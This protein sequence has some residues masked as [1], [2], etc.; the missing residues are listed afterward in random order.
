MGF[1]LERGFVGHQF[2]EHILENPAALKVLDLIFGI[3][4]T[5]HFDDLFLAGL[6]ADD[7][8]EDL[9]WFHGL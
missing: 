6:P 4:S 2:V 9:S 7:Q 3:N 1:L 8:V 5:L